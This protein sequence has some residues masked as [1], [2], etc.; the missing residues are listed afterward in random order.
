MK[1]KRKKLL[2]CQKKE[3]SLLGPSRSSHAY[4][5][6]MLKLQKYLCSLPRRS[7]SPKLHFLGRKIPEVFVLL[8]A[9][10][11]AL[12]DKLWLLHMISAA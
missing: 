4:T 2:R 1:D 6:V 12:P 9:H 7:F 11:W 5:S 10:R 3:G 8:G